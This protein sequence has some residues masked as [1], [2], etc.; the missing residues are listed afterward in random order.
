MSA[1]RQPSHADYAYLTVDEVIELH[2]QALERM[3]QTPEALRDPGL[4]E[5]ALARA[6]HA[7]VYEG[8]DLVRQAALMAVGISENQPFVDGNKRAAFAVLS[9]FLRLNGYR[10]VPD[11]AHRLEIADRLVGIAAR[12]TEREEAEAAFETWLRG[13]VQ[14]LP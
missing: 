12:A 5:S 2:A 10:F 14:P 4:L 6:E 3:G 7:S 13:R 9:V 11:P 8:A 1:E